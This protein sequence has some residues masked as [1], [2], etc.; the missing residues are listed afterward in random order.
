MAIRRLG[1]IM[2]G[3]TSRI[4]TTQHLLKSLIPIRPAMNA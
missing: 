4:G 1:I 3:A 2:H